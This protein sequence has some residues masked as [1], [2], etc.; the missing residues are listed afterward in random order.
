M[1]C[2]GDERR[3]VHENVACYTFSQKDHNGLTHSSR[4]NLIHSCDCWKSSC[5]RK[6]F[7]IDANYKNCVES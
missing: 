5:E 3:A 2:F 4:N 7:K 6:A 1:I